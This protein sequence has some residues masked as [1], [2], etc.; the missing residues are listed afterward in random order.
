MS[1]SRHDNRRPAP[2]GWCRGWIYALAWLPPLG[3]MVWFLPRYVV[4]L[5][6][7]DDQGE[8]PGHV[9]H[10]LA[11]VRLDQ[12]YY[13]LPVVLVIVSAVTVAELLQRAT[14]RE[15]RDRLGELTWRLW[16]VGVGVFAWLFALGPPLLPVWK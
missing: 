4:R 2:D 1:G 14:R 3:V 16:V 8:L 6:K 13:H 12:T 5:Q 11:F 10:A 15:R 7:L 9:H